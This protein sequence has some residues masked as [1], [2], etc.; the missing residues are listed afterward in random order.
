MAPAPHATLQ[1]S[2]ADELTR[3]RAAQAA[4]AAGD[5]ARALALLDA[6]DGAHPRG[7]LRIEAEA[8]RVLAL[9]DAGRRA[10]AIAQADVFLAAHSVSPL[11]GR[12]GRACR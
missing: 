11:A 5:A 1:P 8:V 10:D 3:L 9:C 6:Y 2:L 4:R 12:V 7:A